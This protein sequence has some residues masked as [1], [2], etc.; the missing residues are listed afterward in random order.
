MLKNSQ[1]TSK[2]VKKP[3]KMYENTLKT[4][5][6]IKKPSQRRQKC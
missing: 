6:N 5:K 3:T 1:K 2:N 4:D